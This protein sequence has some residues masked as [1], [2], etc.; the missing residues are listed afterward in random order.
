VGE[1]QVT[2]KYSTFVRGLITEANAISFPENASVDEENFHLHRDGSRERR[3]GINYE[4]GFSKT[5]VDFATEV[6]SEVSYFAWNNAGNS[7]DKSFIVVQAG[8]YIDIFESTLGIYGVSKK[9]YTIGVDTTAIPYGGT[10]DL[11]PKYA[12]GFTSANGA[13]YCVQKTSTPFYITYDADTDLFSLVNYEI[14]VRDIWGVPLGIATD[15]T[16]HPATLTGNDGW[17]HRYNLANQGWPDEAV[18]MS[19]STGT[20]PLSGGGVITANPIDQ[21]LADFGYAPSLADSY[22]LSY[23]LLTAGVA[24]TN[25]E[26]YRPDKLT[27]NPLLHLQMPKGKFIIKAFIKDRS[28]KTSVVYSGTESQDKGSPTLIETFAGRVWYAGVESALVDTSTFDDKVRYNSTLFFSQILETYEHASNCYQQN[29]PTSKDFSTILDTDGGTIELAGA[30]KIQR[31]V[32]LHNFLVVLADNGIWTVTG[33]RGGFTASDYTVR[34][35]SNVG[36]ISSK[37]VVEVEGSLVYWSLSG[38]YALAVDAES[39]D[40]RTQNITESSIQTLYQDIPDVA[41]KTATGFL[42]TSERQVSWLYNNDPSFD[43]IAYKWRKT[44][45]LSYDLVLKAWSVNTISPLASNTPYIIGALNVP[46]VNSYNQLTDVVANGVL[47]EA[48]GVQVQVNVPAFS[49]QGPR[50]IYICYSP[51]GYTFGDYL[52]TSYLDWYSEDSTGIDFVSYLITGYEALDDIAR[53]RQAV[54]MTAHFDR[55]EDNFISDGAGG[56][57]LDNQ[58]GCTL[59]AR[60]DWADHSNS[61]K[62]GSEQQIYRLKRLYTPTGTLPESFDNGFPITSTKNKLR[63]VGR[64]SHLKFTSETGKDMHLLGWQIEY[65]G[66]EKV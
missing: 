64:S 9:R 56:A 39:Q 20:P 19:T 28:S 49:A 11:R 50:P 63:G 8:R 60:W 45:E 66:K 36:C 24:P 44:K 15:I 31:L 23:G 47:V 57:I 33:G 26:M 7:S 52:N 42:D 12:V 13:L 58:S 14:S 2:K 35:V 32:S 17:Q 48:D 54:Y 55:T 5:S 51:T 1:K 25:V 38:I 53:R 40:I 6:E 46:I 59:Q 61:G 18:L 21:T 4:S 41:K 27:T 43:G 34:K 22:Y 10:S 37:S 29:D 30:G 62:W 16:N 65:K 3:L